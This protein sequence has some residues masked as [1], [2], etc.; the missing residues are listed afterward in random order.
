MWVSD[1]CTEHPA[2][3]G[4]EVVGVCLLFLPQKPYK[5]WPFTNDSLLFYQVINFLIFGGLVEV[6][7]FS[8]TLF[9]FSR[10]DLSV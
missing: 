7:F 6:I 2:F 5:G 8:F 10:Q 4:S 9:G 3:S 1:Y